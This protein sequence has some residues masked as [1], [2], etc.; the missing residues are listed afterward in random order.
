MNN[1]EKAFEAVFINLN[2]PLELKSECRKLWDACENQRM[3]KPSQVGNDIF[4]AGCFQKDI[5][6]AACDLRENLSKRA[7]AGELIDWRQAPDWAKSWVAEL[8]PVQGLKGRWM[9]SEVLEPCDFDGRD[10]GFWIYLDDVCGSHP[11]PL[12]GFD[13]DWKLSHILRPE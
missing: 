6:K 11:A 7:K 1:S 12:F 4:C 13:G 5:L 8:S 9:A 3:N 10:G 2:L